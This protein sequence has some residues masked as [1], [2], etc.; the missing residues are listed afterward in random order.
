MQAYLLGELVQQRGRK[1]KPEHSNVSNSQSNPGSLPSVAA[2]QRHEL[3]LLRMEDLLNH[4]AQNIGLSGRVQTAAELCHRMV[5][6]CQRLTTAKRKILEDPDLYPEVI[7]RAAKHKTANK[8]SGACP[9]QMDLRMFQ[10][11]FS[12]SI[13]DMPCRIAM[14]PGWIRSFG[15]DGSVKSWPWFREN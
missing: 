11:H 7:T 10:L 3:T 12:S 15:E 1:Q 4:G 6:F 5:D 9:W 8:C 2:Y 13:L 14:R